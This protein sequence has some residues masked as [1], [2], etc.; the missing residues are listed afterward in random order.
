M[1]GSALNRNQDTTD[2]RVWGSQTEEER[3]AR[4]RRIVAAVRPVVI[5]VR[6]RV[7]VRLRR[8]VIVVRLLLVRIVV[9]A[10]AI[11]AIV[12]IAMLIAAAITIAAAVVVVGVRRSDRE[13]ANHEGKPDSRRDPAYPGAQFNFRFLHSDTTSR[14]RLPLHLLAA[15]C[16]AAEAFSRLRNSESAVFFCGSDIVL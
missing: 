4:G 10:A 8:V 3:D 1:D 13:A 2:E 7:V 5:R 14:D 15:V 6:R 9:A 12:V 11:T 16:L